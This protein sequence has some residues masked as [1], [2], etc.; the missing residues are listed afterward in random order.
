MKFLKGFALV[1]L[2]AVAA[3]VA[4]ADRDDKV[5]K[6]GEG[7][8]VTIRGET[9]REV[10]RIRS[11]MDKEIED[12]ATHTGKELYKRLRQRNFDIDI[13]SNARTE[14]GAEFT[15][16]RQGGLLDVIAVVGL[17]E[18]I[19][20]QSDEAKKEFGNSDSRPGSNS[21]ADDVAKFRREID[22]MREKVIRRA[23]DLDMRLA[24]T[25]SAPRRK[26]VEWPLCSPVMGARNGVSLSVMNKD[27]VQDTYSYLLQ[28]E[29]DL[30]DVRTGRDDRGGRRSAI[31]PDSE[32]QRL[33]NLIA[34][35]DTLTRRTGNVPDRSIRDIR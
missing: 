27:Q 13:L 31:V 14:A 1:S 4:L 10:K 5:F 29:I 26:P 6:L 8:N 34:A 17:W 11:A 12:R 35:L 2:L 32:L 20:R 30:R 23:R 19:D 18:A 7:R 21:R 15:R 16:I 3:S 25:P 24:E 22:R 33:R 9:V 28:Q